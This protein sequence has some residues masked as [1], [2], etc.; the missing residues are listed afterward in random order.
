ML[1]HVVLF[2]VLC[3]FMLLRLKRESKPCTSEIIACSA[4]KIKFTDSS[5]FLIVLVN[6]C[7][8]MGHMAC[9]I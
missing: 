5:S 8:G 9:V 1:C 7:V 6:I 2:C 4:A 3:L